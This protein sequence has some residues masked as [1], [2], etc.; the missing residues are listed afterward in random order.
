M[1]GQTTCWYH[2]TMKTFE[3]LMIDL[4]KEEVVR[5]E[6]DYQNDQFWTA[7]GITYI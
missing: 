4:S 5:A 1:S 3:E 2:M 6:K 7:L